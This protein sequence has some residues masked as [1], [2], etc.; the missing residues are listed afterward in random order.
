MYKP[1][2]DFVWASASATGSERADDVVPDP[3]P[4]DWSKIT[5]TPCCKVSFLDGNT[6]NGYSSGRFKSVFGIHYHYS[7]I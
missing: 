2:F 3:K 7:E 5:K 1:N 6:S 4:I